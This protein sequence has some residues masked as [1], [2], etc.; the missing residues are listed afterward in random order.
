MSELDV[1][2]AKHQHTENTSITCSEI[3]C[4]DG[5]VILQAHFTQFHI[6]WSV[7]SLHSSF[8]REMQS[9]PQPPDQPSVEGCPIIKLSDSE[10]DLTHLL[11]ALYNLL[12]QD[13]A[14][15]SAALI[16]DV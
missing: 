13:P 7:L 12:V 1:S 2:P 16:S 10:A 4:N 9:L 8:F 14:A 5:S 15:V 3:W 11:E 6:H